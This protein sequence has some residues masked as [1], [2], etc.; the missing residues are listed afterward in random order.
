MK[1]P[2]LLILVLF[3]NLIDE[4]PYFALT[5]APPLPGILLAGMTPPIVE[6]E[7]LH[8]MVRPIDYDTN[9]DFIA[10]SF[11]DYLAPHAIEAALKFREKGKLVI[12][13]GKFA[14][15]FPE[16]VLPY[17]DSILV[18]EA[19]G[20]WPKIVEDLIS[21][22][23]KK[24]YHAEHYP[25]LKDIPPP[26]Y[27][28]V[29]S[30]F[31]VPI[32]T[33]TS[34]G[35]IHSCTYC[36]LNIK[37]IPFRTR[38]VK[39]VIRDL[40]STQKLPLYKK[41]MA[42]ILD[43]HFSGD[44]AHAKKLL[45]EIA[46]LNYWAIGFQYSMESLRD[47]EFIDL[48]SKANCRMSF[49]GMES[50]NEKSLIA[51]QKKQNKVNEYKEYFDKLHR[52]GI[53]TFV[54]LMFGLEEDTNEYYEELPEL[55]DEIGAAV[56]LPSITVPIFGTPLYNQLNDEHRI[57]DHDLSHYDGDHLVFKHNN[58]SEDDIYFAYKRVN[59]LFY[60]PS[61]IIRRWIKLINQQS[62]NENI[63]KFIL[64]IFVITF[65]YFKL[66][67]FQRHHAKKRVFNKFKKV[68]KKN[69]GAGKVQSLIS[70]KLIPG[71]VNRYNMFR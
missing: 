49:L 38:P 1:K 30:K 31:S 11:M 19:Q 37:P 20:V 16:L 24:I 10:I 4:R 44:L 21:G 36:Q 67:V 12:G 68:K 51:V 9:A 66:S 56:I 54:G 27:D 18:G 25:S 15:T 13:G 69:I 5:P 46:K 34:R 58:L 41:K 48:L 40:T 47:D 61:K 50:L 6:I 60:S 52:K 14:S 32:V 59:K 42:M 57:H 26:R 65:I 45:K 43:N 53:L 7:V 70:D 64:K 63:A 22:N 2:K 3:Q 55:L 62:I 8:E 33:E 39:D 35:C 71:F 17:F 28:L 23:L 29:E